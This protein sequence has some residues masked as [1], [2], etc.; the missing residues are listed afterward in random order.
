MARQADDRRNAKPNGKD[1]KLDG[2][3]HPHQVPPTDVINV[4]QTGRYSDHGRNCKAAEWTFEPLIGD[5]PAFDEAEDDPTQI[6]Q[7]YRD[8]DRFQPMDEKF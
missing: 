3:R 6:R 5:G 2:G 7:R 4:G 8:A 1:C